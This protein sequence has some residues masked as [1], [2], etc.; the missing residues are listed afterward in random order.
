MHL[1]HVL[2]PA[3]WRRGGKALEAKAP[4]PDSRARLA[5]YIVD[6]TVDP[7]GGAPGAR[8]TSFAYQ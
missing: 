6:D 2:K 5:S 8:Q 3:L 4:T 1:R 7:G